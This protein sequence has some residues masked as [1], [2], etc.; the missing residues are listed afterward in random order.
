MTGEG[1]AGDAS[2]APSTRQRAVGSVQAKA[3]EVLYDE[4]R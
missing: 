3:Q 1:Q 2:T 4:D